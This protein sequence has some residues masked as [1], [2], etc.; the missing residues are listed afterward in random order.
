MTLGLRELRG[1]A[2]RDKF[3]TVTN[4]AS[5][6]KIRR[7]ESYFFAPAGGGGTRTT[8]WH[9][10]IPVLFPVTRPDASRRVA[11]AFPVVHPLVV[12]LPAERP[13]AS[14]NWVRL[15][16]PANLLVSA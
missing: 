12:S 6:G 7:R 5:C 3:V 15:P 14:R 10:P 13:E 16:L 8:L 11:V 9:L 2:A 4:F 1:S